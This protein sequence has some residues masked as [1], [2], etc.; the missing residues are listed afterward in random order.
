LCASSGQREL[1]WLRVAAVISYGELATATHR[2]L[3][4]STLVVALMSITN[5]SMDSTT[6]LDQPVVSLIIRQALYDVHVA[7]FIVGDIHQFTDLKPTTSSRSQR[8]H[9]FGIWRFV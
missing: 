4:A 5:A 8:P 2:P 7:I 9:V 1:R 3:F 6:T